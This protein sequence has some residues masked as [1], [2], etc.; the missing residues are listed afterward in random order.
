[1][2]SPRYS[3]EAIGSQRRALEIS[4]ISEDDNREFKEEFVRSL[5]KPSKRTLRGLKSGKIKPMALKELEILMG[6]RFFIFIF[7][8]L[9][10]SCDMI[11]I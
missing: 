1:L 10:L 8:H 2:D 9:C 4:E 5:L 6:L 7:F 3:I 11:M